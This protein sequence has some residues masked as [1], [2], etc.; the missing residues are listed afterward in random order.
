M[1]KVHNAAG[2][3]TIKKAQQLAHQGQIGNWHQDSGQQK[4]TLD[5]SVH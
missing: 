2:T 5:G 1:S 3:N 4:K